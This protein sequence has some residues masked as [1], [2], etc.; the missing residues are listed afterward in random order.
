MVE[1][2]EELEVKDGEMNFH[3]IRIKHP[4]KGLMDIDIRDTL[5]PWNA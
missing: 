5:V 2:V 1:V 4:T 3:D